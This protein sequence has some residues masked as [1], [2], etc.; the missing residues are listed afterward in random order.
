MLEA[1]FT[2]ARRDFEVRAHISLAAGERLSLF[3]PSG[4][5]KTTCLESI[6]GTVKLD[7]GG[8]VIGGSLVNVARPGRL[9]WNREQPLEARHRG[10]AI[11]RQPTTLFPHLSV[12]DNVAYPDR[13]ARR[14]DSDALEGLL[15]RVGLTG[16]GD[17]MPDALSGGQRQRASL[18]RAIARPFR[19]LLLDEPFSSVDATSRSMLCEVAFTAA[20][21]AE[22][23][24][25]LVTHD[26]T[27][28]QAF[29]QHLG[30][31]D[32][33]S[34]LQ[35]GRAEDLVRQPDTVR[36]AQLVGYTNFLARDASSAWA[37][38][39]D[40]F[41]EG[42]WTGRGVVVR[43]EVRS[44]QPFGARYACEVAIS[45][46]GE[47]CGSGPSLQ[48]DGCVRVHVDKPPRVG[49]RW[50]VTALSPPVVGYADP[51]LNDEEENGD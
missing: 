10:V 21:S 36:V 8:V 12:R 23:A 39:P 30:V 24:A 26:L 14:L 40:R 48:E 50:E 29:G 34:V 22:A 7:V 5:G 42:S 15:S 11:V 13:R 38:H 9:R 32:R 31:M 1:H 2:V 51:P 49:G 28:A 4:A 17:V 27:E 33:G 6:A 45:H 43:G 19:V 25:V 46:D 35:M 16:L 44:V 37:L 47:S 20:A 18:A 3:G 41:A